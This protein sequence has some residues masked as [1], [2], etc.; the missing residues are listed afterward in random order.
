VISV[1]RILPADLEGLAIAAETVARGGLVSYPTETVYGLGCDPFNSNAIRAAMSAK[2]KRIDK[3]FPVLVETVD[4]ARQIA[5]FSDE[6]LKL[7]ARFWP[8]P[9]T[10]ILIAKPKTNSVLAPHG[11]IGVRSPNHAICLRLLAMCSGLLVGTSANKTGHRPATTAMEVAEELGD[12]LDLILD[13]GKTT[14]GVSSTVVD[15]TKGLRVIREGPIS[16]DEMLS[17]LRTA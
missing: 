6:A 15:L 2:G 12:E 13:G 11:T 4:A 17:C 14:L 5:E 16:R 9:L 1:V 8:G 3:P 10:L 7:A